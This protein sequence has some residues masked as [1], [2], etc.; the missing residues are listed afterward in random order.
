MD[1]LGAVPILRSFGKTQDRLCS[2]QVYSPSRISTYESC[3]RQYKYRYIDRIPRD[4][5]S[6]EAFLGSRVHEALNKLYRD[7]QLGKPPSLPD[8]LA[9]YEWDWGRRWHN[10][11]RI[12]KQDYSIDHYKRLGKRCLVTYYQ[13]HKPF[14]RGQTL[15]L[16]HKVTSSLDQ[17]GRY[18]IQGYVDRL[19]R[20]QPGCYEIHDYKT[21]GRLPAQ[22]Q[23]DADRQLAL[24]QLGVA[25]IWPDAEEIE[26][27]WHYLAFGKELRSRRTPEALER[28]KK[29]TIALIDRIEA[30]TKF[31]P[32]KSLLCQWCAYLSICPIWT[33]QTAETPALRVSVPGGVGSMGVS[34]QD[35][36]IRLDL[37]SC[38]REA[39]LAAAEAQAGEIRVSED[40]QLWVHL[41]E[42]TEPDAPNGAAD[43]WIPL[44]DES[45]SLLLRQ[46]ERGRWSAEFVE[47]L[48]R[49]LAS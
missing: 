49:Y 1:N 27:V 30:D 37:R 29:A 12:V 26:L 42:P 46:V 10:Q 8:L 40:G 17:A 9:Y 11:V 39:L 41:D 2:R 19:V 3:P 24:Y 47:K 31:T 25:G 32:I 5:E 6:I 48:E 33:D 44:S 22:D 16:E 14:D 34:D 18:R 4:E 15:G 36:E 23:I 20:V 43:G 21:S 38:L 28:L 13:A 35:D 7:F 45:L